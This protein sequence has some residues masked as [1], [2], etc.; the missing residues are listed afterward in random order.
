M[1]AFLVLA[2]LV[3]AFLV[4]VLTFLVLTFLVLV[5]TFLVLVLTFL[6]LLAFLMRVPLGAV[7]V[8]VADLVEHAAGQGEV[9]RGREEEAP[10]DPRAQGLSPDHAGHG[11]GRIDERKLV[12]VKLGQTA[13]VREKPPGG[14][15]DRQR[16]RLNGRLFDLNAP[17][18]GVDERIGPSIRI[19]L[20]RQSELRRPKPEFSLGVFPVLESRVDGHADGRIQDR[21]TLLDRLHGLLD[22]SYTFGLCLLLLELLDALHQVAHF[23]L[24]PAQLLLEGIHRLLCPDRDR[25]PARKQKRR[26]PEKQFFRF[27]KSHGISFRHRGRD[28]LLINRYQKINLKR[29]TPRPGGTWCWQMR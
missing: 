16:R 21:R 8:G 13:E 26:A 19:D 7:R 23:L 6:V 29:R 14:D 3:L 20:G 11:Q 10:L 22:R 12:L 4:L 25:E 15:V 2:F 28:M 1:L 24:H 17:F 27:N 5:L 9:E 18:R